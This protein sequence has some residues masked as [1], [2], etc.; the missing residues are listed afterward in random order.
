MGAVEMH[1]FF[2]PLHKVDY[3]KKRIDL[4]DTKRMKYNRSSL[5]SGSSKSSELKRT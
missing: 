3:G 5:K 4:S 1:F 2:I